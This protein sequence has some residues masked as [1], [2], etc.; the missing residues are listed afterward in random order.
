MTLTIFFLFFLFGLLFGSFGG[1]CVYRIPREIPLGAIKKRRSFCVR[2]KKKVSWYDNIPLVS[3]LI[4]KGKCR[5]C[6]KKISLQYPLVEFLVACSFVYVAKIYNW[7]P[8]LENQKQIYFFFDLYF[9]WSLVVLTFIDIEFRIIPDRFSI[10]NWILSLLLVVFMF[11]KFDSQLGEYIWGGIFGFG[12]FFLIGYTYEKLK[13]VEGLGFGDVKMMG[14]LGT[15]LGFTGMPLL[16]LSGSV[17]G[18]SVGLLVILKEKGNLKT[19]IPFGPFLA[20][21]AVIVWT[22]Q[23]MKVDFLQIP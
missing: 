13:K 18:L 1:M 5:H 21:G 9:F 23:K 11:L 16:I 7:S 12:V 3:Y 2:C 8:D 17:L 19:A 22:L 15:W 14:W 10:G 4:L 20:L 6:R